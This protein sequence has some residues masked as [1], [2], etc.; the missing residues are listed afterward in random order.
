MPIKNY[1]TKVDV[2][3]TLG[4]IQGMLVKHGANCGQAIAFKW[5]RKIDTG[6]V[7]KQ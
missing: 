3:Q 6:V 5:R 4:E 2:F 7:Y 1:S